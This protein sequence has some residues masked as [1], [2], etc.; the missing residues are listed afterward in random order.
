[1]ENG[2]YPT[3]DAVVS[4]SYKVKKNN[5]LNSGEKWSNFN[6]N[7]LRAI[8]IRN[9][10]FHCTHQILREFIV[11]LFPQFTDRIEE[12]SVRYGKHGKSLQVA[13]VLFTDEDSTSRAIEK[14]H[15]IRFEGRD[16]RVTKFDPQAQME[17]SKVAEIRFSFS[18]ISN[19]MPR[20]ILKKPFV[21][22]LNKLW[23]HCR[24]WAFVSIVC[25]LRDIKL[26]TVL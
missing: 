2:P 21:M 14:L 25:H 16:L 15:A 3:S 9:L 11:E 13:C 6:R 8:F 10:P 24:M 22:S 20:I 26:V 7:Q 19:T 23:D 17:S 1:V 5:S 12:V 4:A 18:S